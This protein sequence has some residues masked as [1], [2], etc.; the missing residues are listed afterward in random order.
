MHGNIKV[1]EVIISCNKILSYKTIYNTKLLPYG[2]FTTNKLLEHSLINNWHDSRSIPAKRQN[3]ERIINVLGYTPADGFMQSLGVS[4]TD[5]FWIKDKSSNLTWEDVNF[6][7]NE[8]S[9]IFL[10]ASQNIQSSGF[11]PDFT[12]DGMLEKFWISSMNEPILIKFDSMYNNLLAANE[13]VVFHI[14][15]ELGIKTTPYFQYKIQDR[16]ACACPC[17]IKDKYTDYVNAMQIRH[18]HIGEPG[19]KLVDFMDK[20]MNLKSDLDNIRILDILIHNED[21]HEKNIGVS[22][23]NYDLNTAELIPAFDNGSCLGYNRC[24]NNTISKDNMKFFGK[25]REDVV[26]DITIIPNIDLNKIKQIIIDIYQLYNISNERLKYALDE[27]EY[28]YYI[29]ENERNLRLESEMDY[30][31]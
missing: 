14:A 28:G 11:S 20:N 21:R 16:L 12:T 19:F 29:L 18:M 2:T 6:Y 30:E 15:Q 31:K 22:I 10:L 9:S 27:V 3:L 5:Q 13:V 24:S 23:Q 25:K 26:K 7:D 1:A 8:F 4:L 17:Y